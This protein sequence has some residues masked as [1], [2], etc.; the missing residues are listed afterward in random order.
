MRNELLTIRGAKTFKEP[1]TITGN[2]KGTLNKYNVTELARTALS[3]TKS[4]EITGMYTVDELKANYMEADILDGVP[5]DSILYQDENSEQI[6]NS[7]VIFENIAIAGDINAAYFMK[8]CNLSKVNSSRQ[9]RVDKKKGE[10][11]ST[12]N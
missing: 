4:Q 12:N 6:I 3:K 8:G 11:H 5:T 2:L 1:V 7:D 9:I 10:K